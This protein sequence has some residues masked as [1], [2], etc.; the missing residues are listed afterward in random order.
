VL[1][2][3]RFLYDPAWDVVEPPAL[4][5][6]DATGEQTATNPVRAEHAP[7]GLRPRFVDDPLRPRR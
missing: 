3:H 2:T 1:C 7:Y 6:W 4:T 5:G